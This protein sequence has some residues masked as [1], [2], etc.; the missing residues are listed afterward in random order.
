MSLLR[1]LHSPTLFMPPQG[2]IPIHLS[3]PDLPTATLPLHERILQ[4]EPLEKR[5]AT[6]CYSKETL[7]V[8]EHQHFSLVTIHPFIRWQHTYSGNEDT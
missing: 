5:R 8:V 3:T 4:V 7:F 6:D 1:Q 2:F